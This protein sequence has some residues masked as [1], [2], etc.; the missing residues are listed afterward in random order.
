MLEIDESLLQTE[1]D[2][3]QGLGNTSI[4]L[5]HPRR[6]DLDLLVAL[7][8]TPVLAKN[9]CC[10][11][12]PASHTDAE[13]WYADMIANAQSESVPFVMIDNRGKFIGA[14]G[15]VMNKLGTEAEISVMIHENV[16]GRNYATQAIQAIADFAFSNPNKKQPLLQSV[17]ARCRV[18][19]GASRR[20]AEKCG[21][22]YC[23]TGMAHSR[24]YDG[25]IPIDRYRLDRGIWNALRHWA[26]ASVFNQANKGIDTPEIKGAA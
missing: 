25:M 20:V 23:G 9:M 6:A 4:I 8:T 11:W 26:G 10:N 14:I 17:T 12:L 3:I 15:L 18:T 7:A 19:C 24:H 21:F 22:Q 16:W 5:R 1:P 13:Q 2:S